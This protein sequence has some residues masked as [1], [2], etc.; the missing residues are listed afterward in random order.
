MDL[1][2]LRQDYRLQTLDERTAPSDPLIL[3]RQWLEEAVAS[4]LR[5]PNAMTLATATAEGRP[6]ARIV[7]LKSFDAA[8]FVFFSNYESR[9]GGELA[10]NPRA[11]LVFYWNEL[12]R[13]V[14]IHGAVARTSREETESYFQTRPRGARAGAIVSAQSRPVA[15]RHDLEQRWAEVEAKLNE[16]EAPAPEHWGGYRV[17]PE[18]MEFWQGRSS[19]LH[20]RL[21]YTFEQDVWRITR[22]SP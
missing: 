4:G 3:F 14:R 22:L 10:A 18:S 17:A 16:T 9:K 19:R 8:G 5:E 1:A 6:S 15:S 11:E 21:L 7:L 2:A 20:D 13:Q 12:E